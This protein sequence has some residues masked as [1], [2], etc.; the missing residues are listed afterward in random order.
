MHH[1]HSDRNNILFL[2][3]SC[4]NAKREKERT[5]KGE[6]DAYNI[7]HRFWPQSLWQPSEGNN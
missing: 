4:T 6:R 2:P 5:E 1:A 3:R 7:D